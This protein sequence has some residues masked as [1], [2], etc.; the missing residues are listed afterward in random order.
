MK[1]ISLWQPWAT[2]VAW[3]LKE[4]ETRHWW[5][6]YRG[7]LVI[8]AAKRKMTRDDQALWSHLHLLAPEIMQQIDDIPYGAIVAIANLNDCRMMVQ[9]LRESTDFERECKFSIEAQTELERLV[10]NWQ[11]G[12]YAWQLGQVQGLANPIPLRGQQ[13]LWTPEPEV[14]TA[15]KGAIAVVEAL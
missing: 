1:V 10:G 8:H 9:S 3:G 7:P 2:L 15:I 6:S 5:T 12:R 14:V 4:Y 13:G 11:P